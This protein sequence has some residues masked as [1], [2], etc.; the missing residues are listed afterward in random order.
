[1]GLIGNCVYGEWISFGLRDDG[2]FWKSLR[3]FREVGNRNCES[4]V[5]L[6]VGNYVSGPDSMSLLERDFR[7]EVHKASR[8]GHDRYTLVNT[9]E[10]FGVHLE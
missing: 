6:D 1:M 3:G 7:F 4:F 10:V 9:K 8:S 5:G 2:T